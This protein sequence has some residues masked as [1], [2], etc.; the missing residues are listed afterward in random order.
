M[1]APTAAGVHDCLVD[2]RLGAFTTGERAVMIAN[3]RR[4]VAELNRRARTRLRAS[5]RLGP[6][7][8]IAGARAFAIGDRVVARRNARTLGGRQ[9]R[10]RARDRD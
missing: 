4:D 9:R 3:R 6:D 10:R 2:D 1:T 7:E 5:G 8:L